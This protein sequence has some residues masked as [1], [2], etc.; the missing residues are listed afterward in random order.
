MASLVALCG[1]VCHSAL[2]SL[3]LLVIDNDDL[4]Q[5]ILLDQI[6]TMTIQHLLDQQNAL[7]ASKILCYY[8]N[9]EEVYTCSHGM[10]V[11]Y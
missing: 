4:L 5:P 11:Y 10:F 2:Q 8:A 1:E 7:L 9:N 6:V 3:E